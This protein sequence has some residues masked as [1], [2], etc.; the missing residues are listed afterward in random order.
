MAKKELIDYIKKQISSGHDEENI[1][2]H[3]VSFGH[4]VREIDTAIDEIKKPKPV[5]APG[6]TVATIKKP[7]KEKDFGISDYLT[8]WVRVFVSPS[9]IF[10]KQK[11]LAKFPNSIAH[12]AI[13]GVFGGIIGGL[14]SVI[15]TIFT[16]ASSE[17][18][19]SGI[20]ISMIFGKAGAVNSLTHILVNPL[21]AILIWIS[22]SAI[23][24]F[25][26]L[27]IG[28][29]KSFRKQSHLI[30]VSMAPI[31]FLMSMVSAI[32]NACVIFIAYLLAGILWFYPL[33]FASKIS[34]GFD[35]VKAILAWT[36]PVIVI[37]AYSAP[38]IVSIFATIVAAC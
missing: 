3:L 29:K 21:V 23:L 30:A 6:G 5:Q 19:N 8:V 17:P 31:V 14:I 32:P 36:I 26:S 27:A 11:K 25:F 7:L 35:T 34:Q 28:G 16:G 15:I 2:Q 22:F 20:G 24:H 33:T 1:R 4:K 10:E 38:Y 9:A 12:L 13:A 18:L 37:F